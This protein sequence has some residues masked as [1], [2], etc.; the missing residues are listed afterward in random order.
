MALGNMQIFIIQQ[1]PMQVALVQVSVDLRPRSMNRG[2][3]GGIQDS[4][5]NAGQVTYSAAN[6]IQGVN[7][8]DQGS[9]GYSAKGWIAAHFANG[10]DSL[11]E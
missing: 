8:F 7:F 9:L 6:A 3:F 4:V 11:C 1:I 5:V 10:I 2:S